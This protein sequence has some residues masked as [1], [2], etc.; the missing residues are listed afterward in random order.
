MLV[1]I[2][3]NLTNQSLDKLL[4]SATDLRKLNAAQVEKLARTSIATLNWFLET[5]RL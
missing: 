1:N 2:C 3:L 4:R 5:I